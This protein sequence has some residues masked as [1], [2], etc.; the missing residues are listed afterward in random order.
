MSGPAQL[1]RYKDPSG[2]PQIPDLAVR[3]EL[4]SIENVEWT[5]REGIK[6]YDSVLVAYVAPMGQPKSEASIEIERTLPDGTVKENKPAKAKYAEQ[7]KHYRAGTDAEALGTPLK[8]LPGMTPATIQNLK[9]RGIYTVEMLASV[10]DGN[11]SGTMGMHD[12]R[13]KARKMVETREHDAPFVKM[14]AENDALR[15]QL[16]T[17]ERQMAE[18]TAAMG[19]QKAERPKKLKEAA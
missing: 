13:D 15:S 6:T 1:Y 16:Q 17:L 11:L 12:M 7:L 10:S 9:A 8:E 3:F 18:L 5:N 4:E 14:Q 2:S 19:N